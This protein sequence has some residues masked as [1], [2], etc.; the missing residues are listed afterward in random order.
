MAWLCDIRPQVGEFYD[1]EFILAETPHA[2][3]MLE[4]E[5]KVVLD[6]G[7]CFGSAATYFADKGAE[8][9]ISI[10]PEI[11]NFQQLLHNSRYYPNVI[12]PIKAAV[13]PGAY[14]KL[15]KTAEPN[16]AMHTTDASAVTRSEHYEVVPCFDIRE[17]LG[18]FMPK[19]VK[20]DC[21]GAE[22]DFYGS[23]LGW[24]VEQVAM[25]LHMGSKERVKKAQKLVDAF[26]LAGWRTIVEPE[27]KP[28]PRVSGGEDVSMGVWFK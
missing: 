27:M 19:I 14:T 15:F 20:V 21:E 22:F 1:D 24:G 28:S 12:M 10:E 23:L 4:V 6:I 25:E 16:R 8:R 11:E 18:K 7:G 2:Y 17:L 5:G 13:G 3:G 9:V 26:K